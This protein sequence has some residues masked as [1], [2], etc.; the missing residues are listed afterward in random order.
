MSYRIFSLEETSSFHRKAKQMGVMAAVGGALL[1]LAYALLNYF[2]FKPLNAID[3]FLLFSNPVIYLAL[4]PYSIQ[5]QKSSTVFNIIFAFCTFSFWTGLIFAIRQNF[6][7]YYMLT[8]ISVINMMLFVMASRKALRLYT[9]LTLVPGI[10]V[11]MFS[12]IESIYLWTY[13]TL[14]AFVYSISYTIT[15]QRNTLFKKTISN[16]NILK[17]L[18]Q[19]AIDAIFL[20]DYYSKKILDAN[21]KAATMF[22]YNST[23]ELINKDYTDALFANYNEVAANRIDMLKQIEINGYYETETKFHT[24]SGDLFW[25]HLI[26]TPFHAEKENFYLLQVRNIDERKKMSEELK[27]NYDIF[28]FIL[29][30]LHAFIYYTSYQNGQV[31]FEYISPYISEIFGINSHEFVQKEKQAII[32]ERYHPDDLIRLKEIKEKYKQEKKTFT[33]E[34]RFK[35]IGKDQYVRIRE[36]VVPRLNEKGEMTNTLGIISKVSEDSHL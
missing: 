27:K 23:E 9:L 26:I 10:V 1:A 28:E 30:Q 25:G 8:F 7:L 35:P 13:L 11:L 36:T 31:K 33:F 15:H 14:L 4:I 19:S 5:A 24:R 20:V 2:F 32:Q 17:S 21:K 6:D 29:N 22:Q 3:M 16:E 34:Y 18:L 12:S